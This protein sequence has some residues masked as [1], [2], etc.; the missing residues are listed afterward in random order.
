MRRRASFR[1]ILALF[2]LSVAAVPAGAVVPLTA[3]PLPE[4]VALAD[5]IALGKV[6]AVENE[7]VEAAPLVKIPGVTKKVT[8]R[9]ALV[10]IQ[11]SLSGADKVERL[12]VGFAPPAADGAKPGRGTGRFALVRLAAGDEGCFFLRKHPDEPFYVA[13]ASYDF[14]DKA[15]TKGFDKEIAEVRRCVRLLGDA[16]TGLESKQAED[17]LLTA[18]LLIYRYRT[19]RHVYRG[20]PKTEPVDAEQ[21]KCILAA[22][23]EGDWS[24]RETPAPGS[25]LS[26]F[27][28]LGLSKADGWEPPPALAEV[29]A[30]A[31]KW[32]REHADYRI[33]R[34]VPPDENGN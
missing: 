26:L 27:L 24:A 8:F 28:R 29:P 23:A 3:P 2:L 34:Y 25:P 20:K 4:R 6:T 15:K 31:R 17:R 19:P 12:R 32:L 11:S 33:L 30:A 21:S 7:P 13:A 16:K 5:L 18:A 9:V 14:L 22:L 1:V 10:S